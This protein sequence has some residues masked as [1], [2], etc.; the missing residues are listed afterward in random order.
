VHARRELGWSLER[1]R[2]GWHA[3]VDA[4]TAAR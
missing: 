3:L 2:G 1:L 4:L